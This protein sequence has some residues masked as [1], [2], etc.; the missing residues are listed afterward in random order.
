MSLTELYYLNEHDE[1]MQ[2]V[3]DPIPVIKAAFDSITAEHCIGWIRHW[4]LIELV[5]VSIALLGKEP[6]YEAT[7]IVA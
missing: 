5:L 2:I 4:I 3:G 7:S 6:G 1:I